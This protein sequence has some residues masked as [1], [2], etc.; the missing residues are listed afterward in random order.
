[1]DL[2]SLKLRIRS[3]SEDPSKFVMKRMPAAACMLL[4]EQI[5]CVRSI[6]YLTT[7]YI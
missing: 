4:N 6:I 3:K 2:C 5:N 7:N 1:M